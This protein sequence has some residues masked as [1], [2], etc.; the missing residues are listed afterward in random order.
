MEGK[1][2]EK[3]NSR[4]LALS[5]P[6][7]IFFYIMQNGCYSPHLSRQANYDIGFIA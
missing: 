5:L 3:K 2:K 7:C 4:L 6:S 1:K